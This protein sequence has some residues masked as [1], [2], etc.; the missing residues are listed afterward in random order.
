LSPERKVLHYEVA[1]N[2]YKLLTAAS[3]KTHRVAQR[4]NL[5]FAYVGSMPSPDLFVIDKKE[6]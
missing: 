6:W 1:D 3:G 2:L 4:M 5:R